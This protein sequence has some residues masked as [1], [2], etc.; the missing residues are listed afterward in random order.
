MRAVMVTNRTKTQTDPHSAVCV[1]VRSVTITRGRRS[2]PP[3]ARA[4]PFVSPLAPFLRCE[5]FPPP[6]SVVVRSGSR[7]RDPECAAGLAGGDE[8]EVPAVGFDGLL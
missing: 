2:R 6:L 8:R 1:F 7:Q 4:A 3:V 5:P